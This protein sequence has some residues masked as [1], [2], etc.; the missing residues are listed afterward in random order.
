MRYIY[1]NNVIPYKNLSDDKTTS[2]GSIAPCSLV[3]KR[4][5]ILLF[6]NAWRWSYTT[7]ACSDM[8]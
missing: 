1:L 8:F 4:G 2:Y 3:M 5:D 7:E 6:T